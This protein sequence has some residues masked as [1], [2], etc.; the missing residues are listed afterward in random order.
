MSKELQVI[1]NKITKEE[2]ELIKSQYAKGATDTELKLFINVAEKTGLDPLRRQIHFVKRAGQM[3]IQTGIDGYR[4]IAASTGV[5]SG[6][7][8]AIYDTEKAS[9]PNKATVTVYK[10]VSGQRV[11]FTATARWTE[12]CPGGKQG[13]MWGK[14]P[15]LMLAKCAEALA[16]RK[17]FPQQL[18]G[19]YTNEEM[20]QADSVIV[21]TVPPKPT[22]EQKKKEIVKLCSEL[23]DKQ[24]L[25][26][27]SNADEYSNFVKEHSGVELK[28]EFY[29]KIITELKKCLS[30]PFKSD[31]LKYIAEAFDG[32]LVEEKQ[33]PKEVVEEKPK[34]RAREM[35]EKAMEESKKKEEKK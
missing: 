16:L 23:A 5:H 29:D 34:S 15:Y 10:I 4:A 25:T 35:A 17:A 19:L 22:V 24:K 27:P 9:H 6:T 2:I 32:V 18:S 8:D 21:K 14:M 28:E 26:V 13:F 11:P 3:T 12:Y 1:N 33:E 7:D 30:E 31:D 20:D